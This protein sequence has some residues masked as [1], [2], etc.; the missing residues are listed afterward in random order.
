[1]PLSFSEKLSTLQSAGLSSMMC[2]KKIGLEK[3]C[4]RV[5]SEGKISSLPHPRALGAALTNPYITTDYA[6]PLLELIT[7][8]MDSAAEALQFLQDTEKFVYQNL[9]DEILWNT[10]M[11]CVL[12]GEDSIKIAEYGHSN[13]G[14]MKTVYRRGLGH[15]YGKMMQVIAGVHYNYSLP[16]LFWQQYQSLVKDTS[17]LSDFISNQYMQLTRNLQRYGWLIPYLFGASPAVC[18]SFMNGIEKILEPFDDY[19]YH[20]PYATSLRLSDIGY[21]NYKEG[22]SGIKAN[23][24]SLATYV[25]SLKHATETPCAAF[26]EIGLKNNNEY[27]QLSTNLLQIENEYYSTVRPKQIAGK[28]EKPSVALSKRGIAYIE[29]RSLDVNVLEPLG[30]SEIQLN[31]LEILMLY[32]L[33]QDSPLID[34]TEQKEIDKNQSDT[35]HHGRQ[36]G[37]KLH[38]N[39]KTI[40]L[41][42]WAN[43]LFSDMSG[44]AELLDAGTNQQIYQNALNHYWQS[45]KNP[46]LTPSA[47]ILAEMINNEEPFYPFSMRHSKQIASYFES[48]TLSEERIRFFEKTAEDS[49]KE[50]QRLEQTNSLSF[51]EFLQR[52]YAETLEQ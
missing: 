25:A 7:D 4:L 30:I 11:P 37:L 8:P 15:R 14:L 45:V 20:H 46:E 21:Q 32:C 42:D 13:A 51:D 41:A 28:Y 31:F 44:I 52:Y 3:E 10:S 18:R 40:Q 27:R 50:Q 17:T 39:G 5:N 36:P 2:G 22:K 6:E 26:E 24:D 9:Q 19:T 35:A 34:R 1:M 49:L 29:L 43:E 38:N 12:T 33:L 16:Q 48:L 23:Y 47:Q